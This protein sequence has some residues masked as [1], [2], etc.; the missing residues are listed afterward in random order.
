MILNTRKPEQYKQPDG[1]EIWT[2]LFPVRMPYLQTRD[3]EDLKY[4]G[5]RISGIAELDREREREMI[6]SE[7]TINDMF[8][9][10]RQGITIR[11]K[12]YD[13]TLVIYRIIQAHILKWVDTIQYGVNIGKPEVVRDLI[14]LDEFAAVVYNK[15]VAVF[16]PEQKKTAIA[17]NFLQVSNLNFFNILN[18]KVEPQ[19]P[20]T[21][22]QNGAEVMTVS[23]AEEKGKIDDRPSFKQLFEEKMNS[24]SSW[25]GE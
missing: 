22:L 19:N 24:I 3:V 1:Q 18:R 10:W 2:R 6:D 14:E 4:F 7:L 12:R 16:T 17:T 8:E 15:A 23:Q 25:R 21:T 13:D 11:V 20:L 5:F 9:K